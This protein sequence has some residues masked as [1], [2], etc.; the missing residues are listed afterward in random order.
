MTMFTRLR[1]TLLSHDL[2]RG[3]LTLVAGTGAAQLIVILS[4]PI[5][6]RI[7]A[8][9]DFGAFAVVSA[10]LAILLSIISLRYEFAIP[11]PGSD[12]E[13]ANVLGVCLI[14]TL[15]VSAGSAVVLWIAGPALLA[16]IGASAVTP[17][18]LFLALG[19]LGGGIVTTFTGWA[20][21]TK[22]YSDIAATKF[23]QGISQ[24]VL[25]VGLGLVGWGT[26]GLLLGAIAATVAGA[27]RLVGSAWRTHASVLRAVSIQGMRVAARR[28][29][30]FPIFSAP[31]ALLNTVGIETPILLITVLY[32]TYVG[33]QFAIAQRVIGLPITLVAAA[34]AQAFF[35]EAA[36]RMRE[37]PD[38]LRGLFIQTTRTLALGAIGP[39]ALAMLLSPL[40]FPIV[41][42]DSWQEAGLYIS[43]MVPWFYL[44]F[45]TS[46]TGTTLDVLERQDRHLVREVIRIGFLTGS[47][48]AASALN[49]SPLGAV[50]SL[51]LGGCIT[52]VVYGLISWRAVNAHHVRH[53]IANP[54]S[55]APIALD[56]P[57]LPRA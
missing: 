14:A 56:V 3:A 34:V 46:A 6:T 10:I 5:L 24:V 26:L 21:R 8:V 39:F 23:T 41:F 29:R 53:S 47:M 20:V 42:G 50:A 7:Y 32:G 52:Y 54:E 33:G 17:W 25:Q 37:R 16:A 1:A 36:R 51:S 28:Y 2:F 44:Q 35:A 49:L 4:S 43:V 9:S 31:S 22:S 40:V 15:L 19:A 57:E 45:V 12:Q 38:Q 13:A 11:L 18:L 48:V 27:T 30:R 55:G